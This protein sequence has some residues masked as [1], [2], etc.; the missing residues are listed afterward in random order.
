FGG[1]VSIEFKSVIAFFIIVLVLC[2]R[3]SGLFARHYV[4]KV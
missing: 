3:P 1:Y 2:F 4:K